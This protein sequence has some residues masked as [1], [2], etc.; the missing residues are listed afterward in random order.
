MGNLFECN[1]LLCSELCAT[2]NRWCLSW[3]AVL[4]D[5]LTY[6]ELSQFMSCSV[7][8][9]SEFG[10]VFAKLKTSAEKRERENMSEKKEEPSTDKSFS[11][12]RMWVLCKHTENWLKR[13]DI[14][15]IMSIDKSSLVF[16]VVFF[17]FSPYRLFSLSLS[18]GILVL[19]TKAIQTVDVWIRLCASDW[20]D[21][22]KLCTLRHWLGAG[23][24][25]FDWIAL[26]DWEKWSRIW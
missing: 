6:S 5:S 11:S 10:C 26:R 7:S 15:W 24:C 4:F 21:I 3:I 8:L 16:V 17:L 12:K 9:V 25:G 19:A 13:S 2:L 22:Y 18:F 14:V 23:V 20:M 1:P